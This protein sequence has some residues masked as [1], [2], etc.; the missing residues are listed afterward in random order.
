VQQ[1]VDSGDIT[2]QRLLLLTEQALSAKSTLLRKALA[3]KADS[4]S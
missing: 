1:L 4:H 2:G 3:Q